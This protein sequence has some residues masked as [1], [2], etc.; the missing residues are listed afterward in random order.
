MVVGWAGTALQNV[1][2]F[3]NALVVF[4]QSH[5][6]SKAGKQLGCACHASRGFQVAQVC[7]STRVHDG[8]WSLL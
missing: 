3:E 7:L 4:E 6:A 8:R 2:T 1:D 5:P